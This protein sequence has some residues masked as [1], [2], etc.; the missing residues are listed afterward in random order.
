MSEQQHVNMN[1][2]IQQQENSKMSMG[3]FY[4]GKLSRSWYVLGF[5]LLVLFVSLFIAN[6]AARN[7]LKAVLRS[8]GVGVKRIPRVMKELK[9]KGFHF[10]GVV[11]PLIYLVG[12]NFTTFITQYVATGILAVIT[13]TYFLWECLRL[14]NPTVNQL[15]SKHLG[16]LM[17][18]KERNAF[19]GSLFFLLGATI[20]VFFYSAQVAIASLLF[21]ILGDFMAALVGISIGKIKI[22]KKSLEGSVAC[23]L[24]CF[25]VSLI[26]FWRVPLGEQ[27]AFWGALSA[28]LTELFNP[29]F[30]D[31][32]LSIP[33]VSG[34]VMHIIAARLSVN[35]PRMPDID[36]VL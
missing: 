17:R 22:G 26:L 7:K 24:T 1:G 5:V 27:L 28:T 34:L 6:S 18:D 32:N 4:A 23:F 21:L 14:Y 13:T 11:V 16:F 19:T 3:Y 20:S 10:G 31:D 9:R 25:F 30:V 36:Q 12:L 33:V 35:I 29:E 15:Y 8:C 2:Q